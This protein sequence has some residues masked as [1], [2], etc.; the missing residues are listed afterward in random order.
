MGPSLMRSP[1]TF[2]SGHRWLQ[3]C[4]VYRNPDTGGLACERE[5]RNLIVERVRRLGEAVY[6]LRCGVWGSVD[7][8]TYNAPP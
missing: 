4:G 1:E 8:D 7:T 5:D 6:D 3:C 2:L